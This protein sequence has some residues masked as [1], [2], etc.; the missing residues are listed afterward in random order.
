MLIKSVQLVVTHSSAKF[1]RSQVIYLDRKSVNGF[2]HPSLITLLLF[3]SMLKTNK[4]SR[5]GPA[6]NQQSTMG[7]IL[8]TVDVDTISTKYTTLSN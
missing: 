4:P 1:C 3:S 5:R 2:Q 7:Q 6:I 8:N